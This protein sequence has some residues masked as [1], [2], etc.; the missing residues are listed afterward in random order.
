MN[1]STDFELKKKFRNLFPEYAKRLDRATPETFNQV[2]EQIILEAKENLKK[3]LRE[4]GASPELVEDADKTCCISLS[5]EQY[6]KLIN[7]RGDEIKNQLHVVIDGLER[8]K[9][10]EKD[11]P[12]IVTAQL[13]LSGTLG[14]GLISISTVL[15]SLVGGAIEAAAAF[16][17]VSAATVLVVCAIVALVIVTVLIPIIYFALKPANCIVLL[18]N[19]TDQ[20]LV[21][22]SD[23]NEHGKSSLMTTP[24][25]GGVVIPGVG[26][27]PVAGLIATEKSSS[28]LIGT[29]YGFSM[30]YGK[31][32]NKKVTFGVEC[33]LTSM[34]EDNNCYCA[35]DISAKEAAIQTASHNAQE[36]SASS[37]DLKASIICNSGSGSIA[38]YVARVYK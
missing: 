15:T 21:F 2:H 38:Y 11:E 35:F 19:E 36:S 37:G 9:G 29:Q 26:T 16:A 24:I 3:A 25:Q 30:K 14:V 22:D 8:L 12:G 10:M 6:K 31:S 23:Y 1:Y 4:A 33:P 34:Y 5:Q 28:A 13:L 18:I 32:G 17:G 7:A 20:D 27:Y